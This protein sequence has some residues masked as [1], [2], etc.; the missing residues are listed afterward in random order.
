MGYPGLLASSAMLPVGCGCNRIDARYTMTN[1]PPYW[2]P[3]KRYGWGWGIPNVWQGWVVMALFFILVLVG[4]FTLLP[5]YGS[6]AFVA[7][8]ACLCAGL[9]AVCWIKGEPPSWRSDRRSGPGG[10]AAR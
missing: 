10:G 5:K 1:P 2:F 4:A 3:A 6:L 8:A 9:V 7:Y